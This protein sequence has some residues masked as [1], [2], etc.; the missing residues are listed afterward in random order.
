MKNSSRAKQKEMGTPFI[1]LTADYELI[2]RILND[3][4]LLLKLQSAIDIIEFRL[5]LLPEDKRYDL[6]FIRKEVKQILQKLKF[7]FPI[8]LTIR[9]TNEGG[10]FNLKAAPITRLQI[11][12]ELA[13]VINVIDIEACTNDVFELLSAAEVLKLQSIV[14]CHLYSVK[15]PA[16]TSGYLQQLYS[17]R[18]A[19]YKLAFTLPNLQ[20]YC[21]YMF[22]MQSKHNLIVTILN[23]EP[24]YI[25]AKVLTAQT[26]SA[27]VYCWHYK[28]LSPNQLSLDFVSTILK[29][30]GSNE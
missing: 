8:L 17:Y 20:S 25:A 15:T 18:A 14:S 27:A 23:T 24:E 30:E 4:D 12:K 21:D 6:E 26:I 3:F 7:H 5:D 11:V 1:I 22:L 28:K 16:E 2:Q 10:K 9:S 29:K 13:S 19:Y